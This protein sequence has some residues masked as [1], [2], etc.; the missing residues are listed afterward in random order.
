MMN[1]EKEKKR[2]KKNKTRKHTNKKK[3]KQKIVFLL[4]SELPNK[5]NEK[6]LFSYT[7]INTTWYILYIEYAV[8]CITAM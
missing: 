7:Y 3:V 6:L 4:N 2:K 8:Y 5:S 1:S